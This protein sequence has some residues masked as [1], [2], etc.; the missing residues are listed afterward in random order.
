MDMNFDDV[1]R[2]YKPIDKIRESEIVYYK[3]EV[4]ELCPYLSSKS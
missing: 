4:M 3:I 2:Y 1:I